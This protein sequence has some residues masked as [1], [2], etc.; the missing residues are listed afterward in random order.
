MGF[1]SDI[2][3]IVATMKRQT[4]QTMLFTATWPREVQRVAGDLLKANHVKVTVGNGGD[5]LTA[6]TQVKQVVRVV[7]EN[8]KWD[9]F[10]KIMQP[11]GPGGAR[12]GVRVI[13]FANTKRDVNAICEHFEGH[14]NEQG[15]NV[16]SLSGERTQKARELVVAR[17]RKGTVNVVI[18][19]DVAARGLDIPGIEMVV[20]YGS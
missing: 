15:Y 10:L 7:D 17:F 5:K 2:R 4:L 20:N 3:A 16:D 1:E 11:F 14:H 18:A 6:N 9:E 8:A 12:E 19:T 13:V